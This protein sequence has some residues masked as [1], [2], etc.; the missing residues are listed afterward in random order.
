MMTHFALHPAA[1][2]RLDLT[3]WVL[4]RLP[5]NQMD[6][7]DGQTYRRVL[8]PGAR[9]IAVEVVQTAAGKSPELLVT[10]PGRPIAASTQRR[11]GALLDRMLGLSVDLS[12]FYRLAAADRRL[13]AL[14]RPF[15]G[16]KPPRLASTFE[17]L[18]NGIAC[19]QLS[20]VVGIT[21]L[22]RLCAAFGQVVGEDRAFPRPQDLAAARSAHLRKLGFSGRKAETILTLARAV[23]A[24]EFDLEAVA[25]LDD[26]AAVARLRELRGVGRWTAEFALL[27]GLGRID[28]FPAGDVGSRN[29]FQQ[30]LGLAERP[31]YETIYRVL[32]PWRPYRGLLYFYLLLHHMSRS[33]TLQ[34]RDPD[35]GRSLPS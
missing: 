26:S 18:V 11:M 27:R 24:G 6:R 10:V 29:K 2:Y 34:S 15:A 4:R 25:K 28:V 14:I 3:V 17:A 7:W 12:P 19:Q 5:I 9:G 35:A 30:W 1:P 33:G 31:D 23:R 8:L 21:L 13:A 22:N 20:L 32:Q 16:F